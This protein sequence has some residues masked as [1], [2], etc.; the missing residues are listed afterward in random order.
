MVT[1]VCLAG[2][3]VSTVQ[4][5]KFRYYPR[6]RLGCPSPWIC[7]GD[8]PCW[9]APRSSRSRRCYGAGDHTCHQGLDKSHIWSPEP[10]PV[11]PGHLWR[12]L[13]SAWA[14]L[15]CS[16]PPSRKALP[17]D[18]RMK[19]LQLSNRFINTYLECI[20]REKDLIRTF[21]VPQFRTGG[22]TYLPFSKSRVWTLKEECT[23]WSLQS[24][25]PYRGVEIHLSYVVIPGSAPTPT[26]LN[27]MVCFP[28]SI[29]NIHAELGPCP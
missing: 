23:G 6:G 14:V 8:L 1:V 13:C 28:S 3:K 2:P 9:W 19:V 12:T 26:S 20:V 18:N 29:C 22:S 24:V 15:G 17:E 21:A 10:W 5:V 27:N 11:H 4:L 7:C 25:G 16:Q